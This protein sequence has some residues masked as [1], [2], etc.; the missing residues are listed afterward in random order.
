M[1]GMRRFSLLSLMGSIALIAMGF[2]LALRIDRG[3]QTDTADTAC[4]LGQLPTFGGA[5]YLICGNVLRSLAVGS[6]AIIAVVVLWM[7]RR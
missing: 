4:L 5:H 7:A 6:V 1:R 3:I 2:C